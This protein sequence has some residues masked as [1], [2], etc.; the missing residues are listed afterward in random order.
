M[1]LPMAYFSQHLH[2]KNGYKSMEKTVNG[3]EIKK[4]KRNIVFISQRI[5]NSFRSKI[6]SLQS[7]GFFFGWNHRIN[8]ENT[9]ANNLAIEDA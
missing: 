4:K 7:S 9:N 5:P 6:N 3:K 8:F 1:K 2:L